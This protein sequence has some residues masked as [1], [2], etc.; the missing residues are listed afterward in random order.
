M[1]ETT[2]YNTAHSDVDAKLQAAYK[3]LKYSGNL[4][5]FCVL[6]ANNCNVHPLTVKNYLVGSGKDG[7][8]KVAILNLLNEFNEAK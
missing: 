5:K 8:L 1:K 3:Q 6:A 4:T 2:N 7:F